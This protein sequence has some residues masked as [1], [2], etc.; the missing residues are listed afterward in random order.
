MARTRGRF[1]RPAPRTKMWIGMGVGLTAM[2]A[3]AD[4]LVSTL[5]AGAL[6]LRPF[7]I[8]RSHLLVQYESDQET[9][10]EENW[11]AIGS[12]VVTDTAAAIGITAVPSP[13]GTAG[14]PESDWYLWQ[15]LECTFR[16]GSG[17][18][19]QS[20]AGRQYEIDS[21]AMRK[22]GADD[23]IAMVASQDAAVGARLLTAGRRLIQ[24]H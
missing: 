1:I 13:S 12:I 14:D 21:K 15:A 2:G 18:G 11:G 3:S 22:V 8:I 23:D 20:S 17:V 5:S 9:T 7:T 10:D 24:L 19:F 4:V 6:L 16:F